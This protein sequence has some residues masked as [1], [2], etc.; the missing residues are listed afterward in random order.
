M[1]FHAGG[2]SLMS[3]D[4]EEMIRAQPMDAVVRMSETNN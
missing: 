3:M 4:A 2:L 1:L